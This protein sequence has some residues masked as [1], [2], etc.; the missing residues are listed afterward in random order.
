[1][2]RSTAWDQPLFAFYLKRYRNVAGASNLES[3][4]GT[5]TFGALGEPL[6][7]RCKGLADAQ[8]LHCILEVSHMWT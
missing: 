5:V 2:A 3:D 4:G 8:T 1:M 7:S 6:S